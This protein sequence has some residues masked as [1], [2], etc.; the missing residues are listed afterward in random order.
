MGDGE[1]YGSLVQR[2][3]CVGFTD[4]D[5]EEVLLV[6]GGVLAFSN[7]QFV[8]SGDSKGSCSLPLSLHPSLSLVRVSIFLSL[9]RVPI[10]PS[11]SLFVAIVPISP[12]LS[13]LVRVPIS[14]PS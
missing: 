11:L 4:G 6:V 7:V 3:K 10:S 8:D 9:V 5:I 1:Q 13:R 14:L 12:F 2:M